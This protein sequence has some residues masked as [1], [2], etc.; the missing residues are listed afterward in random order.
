[1]SEV[2]EGIGEGNSMCLDTARLSRIIREDVSDAHAI[3]VGGGS[4][5]GYRR[6]WRG[7]VTYG[8]EY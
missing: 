6:G 7:P 2:G 1:M 8:V 3:R 5:R 4:D